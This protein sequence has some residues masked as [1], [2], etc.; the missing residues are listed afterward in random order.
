IGTKVFGPMSD[1]WM[2]QGLS[3]RHIR[4]ACETS[5]Q[6]LKT[7]Y[8]DLYQCH[9]YDIDTPLE[10][11]CYAMHNLIERGYILHWGVSQWTAVQILNALRICERNQ[12]HKPVSNQPIYNMLN[13]SLEVDVMGVCE[14]DG[15]GLV[16]YSPLAQ[17]LLSGKY[18]KDHVP[19][20]SRLAHEAAGR[21]FP[22]K[23][24]TE[25]FYAQQAELKEIASSLGLDMAQLALAWILHK[26]PITAAIMGATHPDQVEKNCAASGVVLPEEILSRIEE[27]LDNAP[28]DQYSGARLG[29]GIEKR[30]Y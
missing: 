20:N 9:R 24:M 4:T 8:I 18:E 12:W 6:R 7:D 2:N 28:V 30:G 23:R 15:L 17:G 29:Y 13:R 26:K 3:L 19:E 22:V 27:I 11:T 10:E 1:H 21:F 5:L 25:E 16:V 14:S